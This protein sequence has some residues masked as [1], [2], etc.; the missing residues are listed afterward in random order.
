MR[1]N[2]CHVVLQPPLRGV[3]QCVFGR[4]NVPSGRITTPVSFITSRRSRSICALASAIDLGVTGGSFPGAMASCLSVRPAAEASTREPEDQRPRSQRQRYFKLP[5]GIVR[6][7]CGQTSLDAADGGLRNPRPLSQRLLI[8][9]LC[10]PRCSDV[11]LHCERDSIRL[12]K[13]CQADIP[14][15]RRFYLRG[16]IH[17]FQ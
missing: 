5:D 9:L 16:C 12:R 13:R 7:I 14:P 10:A 8:P 4:I 11:C 1:E 6:G 17:A 2:V 3:R 15:M